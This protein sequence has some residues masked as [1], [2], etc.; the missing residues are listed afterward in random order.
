MSVHYLSKPT[1]RVGP[2]KPMPSAPQVHLEN[3]NRVTPQQYFLYEHTLESVS[4]ILLH[5]ECQKEVL[6]F[7]GR[8]EGVIYIQAGIVGQE[9]YS[10]GNIERAK[11]LVYGRKWMISPDTPSS[12]IVQTAFLA[13]KKLRE[14]EVRELLTLYSKKLNKISAPFSSHQDLLLMAENKELITPPQ[15]MNLNPYTNAYDLQSISDVVSLLRFDKKGFRIVDCLERANNIILDL[16]LDENW[17]PTM[18][19]NNSNT[20]PEFD[21][22]N[23]TLILKS[24]KPEHFLHELV[25]VLIKHSD[26]YVARVFCFKG[27]ARFS[28]HIDTINVAHLSITTRG[29]EKRAGRESFQGKFKELNYATDASRAPEIGYGALAEKNRNIISRYPDLRGHMPLGFSQDFKTTTL[30]RE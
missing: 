12:E 7:A 6:L 4:E 9:N 10:I 18:E 5:I 14:H 28:E 2:L 30:R 8:C 11:K 15:D 23:C 27:F 22:F 20:L 21:Q 26:D 19:A 16:A 24:F 17:N 29:L 3:G 25:K 13:I 1:I